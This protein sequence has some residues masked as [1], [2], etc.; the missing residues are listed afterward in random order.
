MALGTP[1]LG[2]DGKDSVFEQEGRGESDDQDAENRD[3]DNPAARGYEEPGQRQ[4]EEEEDHDP[5]RTEPGDERDDGQGTEAGPGQ[6]DE[7]K[8]ADALGISGKYQ[9]QHHAPEKEGEKQDQ[10][11]EDQ[12]EEVVKGREKVEEIDREHQ[13]RFVGQ[14][15]GNDEEQEIA[16]QQAS[17]DLRAAESLRSARKT[18]LRP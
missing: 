8:A 1:Q 14:G 18:P 10:E 6:V 3:P 12:E 2:N 13:G 11:I 9:G 17:P 7:I 16:G 4:E 5:V 15:K